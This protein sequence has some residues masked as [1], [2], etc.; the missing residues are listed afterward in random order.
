MNAI[1]SAASENVIDD[2]LNY[3]N[4]NYRDNIK[5]DTIAPLFGYNSSYLGK[6]F[7]K[8]IGESFNS[9]ID[10]VRI[11]NSKVLLLQNNM[12]VYEIAEYVGYKS[13][14]YFHKKFKKYVGMSPAEFKKK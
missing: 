11:N 14:D 1:G 10:H 9:Y 4:Q 6:I 8:K 13:V 5:L 2:V 7:N 12:K 3:I